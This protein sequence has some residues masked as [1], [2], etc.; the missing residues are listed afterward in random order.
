M[1]GAARR[2]VVGR[3]LGTGGVRSCC[4]RRAASLIACRLGVSAHRS[5]AGLCDGSVALRRGARSGLLAAQRVAAVA[6]ARCGRLEFCERAHK[7]VVDSVQRV[8]LGSSTYGAVVGERLRFGIARAVAARA[9]VV[10]SGGECGGR[11]AG[12]AGGVAAVS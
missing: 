10:G 2:S 3:K 6:F 9:R 8:A 1:L 7:G 11:S 12:E 5:C 4:W